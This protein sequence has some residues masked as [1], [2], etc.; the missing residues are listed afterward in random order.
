MVIFSNKKIH[1]VKCE[2]YTIGPIKAI[3][4]ALH[5]FETIIHLE[6]IYQAPITPCSDLFSSILLAIS[7]FHAFTMAIL[8]GDYN[9]DML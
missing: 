1:V 8:I 7:T 6:N 5:F 3:M 2:K 9:V 4:L